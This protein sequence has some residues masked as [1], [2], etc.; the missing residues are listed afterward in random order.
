MPKTWCIIDLWKTKVMY[1]YVVK[2]PVF[3]LQRGSAESPLAP[4]V[5]DLYEQANK[6]SAILVLIFSSGNPQKFAYRNLEVLLRVKF[7]TK[8]LP[9]I[10]FWFLELAYYCSNRRANFNILRF[11]IR[12]CFS[13]RKFNNY[14]TCWPKNG[15]SFI[16]DFLFSSMWH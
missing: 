12:N 11:E 16:F 5:L 8:K 10:K 13:V 14:H 4:S 6:I 7:L 3:R 9:Q 2:L 1:C 15:R